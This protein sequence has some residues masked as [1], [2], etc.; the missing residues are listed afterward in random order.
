MFEARQQ[1]ERVDT[2]SPEGGAAL[3]LG[4]LAGECPSITREDD[5]GDVSRARVALDVLNGVP[6]VDLSDGDLRDDH[7]RMNRPRLLLTCS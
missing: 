4:S 3:A 7:V 5:H 2:A 6:A 1:V